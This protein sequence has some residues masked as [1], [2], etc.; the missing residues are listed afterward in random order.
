MR[1]FAKKSFEFVLADGTKVQTRVMDF[2]EVP[3]EVATL[4]YFKLI[5]KDGDIDVLNQAKVTSIN[6]VAEPVLS[7][8]EPKESEIEDDNNQTPDANSNEESGVPK[9]AK[10]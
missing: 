10:K 2:C 1:I 7:P 4:P 3:D 9:K 8:N 5:Q 6:N